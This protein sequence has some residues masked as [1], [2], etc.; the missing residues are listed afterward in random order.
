MLILKNWQFIV[1]GSIAIVYWR[2]A[3]IIISK[4]LT[5]A[6][7]ADFEIAFR[8]FSIAQMLPVIASATIFP[9]FITYYNDNNYEGLKQLYKSVFRYYALFAVAAYAFIY[10][11]SGVII[12][13]VVGN[14][15]PGAVQ[16][17]QQMFLTFLLMPTVLLQANLIVAIGLEKQDMWFNIA[18]VAIN[19][20]GCM[21][22]LYFFKSL[23]V[24][25]YAIFISFAVF[26]ISQD[27]LLITRKLTT[28]KHCAVFYVAVALF[29]L[30][31]NYAANYFNP[32]FL[33][34]LFALLIIAFYF[35]HQAMT[36][37]GSKLTGLS[38]YNNS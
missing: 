3:N 27:V 2:M 5:L 17:L 21:I 11:F 28:I 13:L 37:R 16:C 9:R 10:S 34:P 8:V 12:P 26:H 14:G 29:V 24:V 33:F 6:H 32:Y 30:L 35:M 7:V 25:N 20:T 38:T 19:L 31:Y 4:T 18:S 15:Y 23:S 22:G 36:N 1:I